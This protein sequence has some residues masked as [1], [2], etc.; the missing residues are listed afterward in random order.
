MLICGDSSSLSPKSSN[1]RM[2][3]LTFS[4]LW[5]MHIIS[6]PLKVPLLCPPCLYPCPDFDLEKTEKTVFLNTAGN[7]GTHLIPYEILIL[8]Q[9]HLQCH[10]THR[11]RDIITILGRVAYSS[12]FSLLLFHTCDEAHLSGEKYRMVTSRSRVA[13]SRLIRG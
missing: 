4:S 8:Q 1:L 10:C 6:V 3:N 5:H 7:V 9:Y 11:T 13:Q 12:A 2:K